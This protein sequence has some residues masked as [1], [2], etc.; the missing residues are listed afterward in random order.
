MPP[1]PPTQD[2]A[3][4]RRQPAAAC[5]AACQASL[6][7][8]LAP[9]SSG[10]LSA[11]HRPAQRSVRACKPPCAA[12]CRPLHGMSGKPAAEP[13]AAAAAALH[14][15]RLSGLLTARANAAA[16]HV[17]AS[18]AAQSMQRSAA[19]ALPPTLTPGPYPH[20]PTLC[21]CMGSQRRVL[22]CS[23]GHTMTK[24]TLLHACVRSVRPGS[25]LCRFSRTT[26]TP[27]ARGSCRTGRATECC[28]ASR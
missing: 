27:P 28:A 20:V 9:C 16:A 22:P 5:A 12:L 2:V 17:A 19:L 10:A 14:C 23:A 11:D 25:C 8:S 3:K 18:R 6:P 21:R 1:P 13:A 24:P 26:R 15:L 4:T 7:R